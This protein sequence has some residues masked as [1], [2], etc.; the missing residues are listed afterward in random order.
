[1]SGFEYEE[2][3]LHPIN[4]AYLS[5]CGEYFESNAEA[6]KDGII[7]EFKIKWKIKKG[8]EHSDDIDDNCDACNWD[9]FEVTELGEKL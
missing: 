2:Y 3:E 5:K 4:Q 7:Y 1:M 9:E 6:I 8:Y